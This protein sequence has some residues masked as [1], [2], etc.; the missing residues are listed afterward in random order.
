MNI[1]NAQ[2]LTSVGNISQIRNDSAVEIAV[3]GKSNVGKSSFINF[4]CNQ[5]RLAKT[6]SEPGRTRLLNY[7]LINGGEFTLVDLPGYGFARVSAA[8][9]QQWGALIEAYLHTSKTLKCVFLL[10]D[11]RHDPTEDDMQMIKY[12]YFYR[13]PFVLIATKA[14][15]LSRAAYMD[16]AQKIATYVGVGVDNLIV[17]SAVSRL[18]KEK[19]L[20]KIQEIINPT[21]IG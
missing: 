2:F 16:R 9:K 17:S 19:I 15:K 20:E 12:L 8:E 4:L 11:V 18:G 14:D 7:F 6:S 3:A 13:I 21:P 10:L 5:K 1:K